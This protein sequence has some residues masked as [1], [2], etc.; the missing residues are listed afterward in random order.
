[1]RVET[2]PSEHVVAVG[3]GEGAVHLE[4]E[5]LQLG[6]SVRSGA[7]VLELGLYAGTRPAVATHECIA[8]MLYRS[9]RVVELVN[10]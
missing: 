2:S 1:M 9:V 10:T 5:L 3:L 7:V 4:I 6:G 8:V